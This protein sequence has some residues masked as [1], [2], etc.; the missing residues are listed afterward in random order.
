MITQ[1][2]SG[3]VIAPNGK[4]SS[5][6]MEAIRSL[7]NPPLIPLKEEEIYVRRCRLA[8]DVIDSHGGCFRSEDLPKLL[9]MTW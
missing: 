7:P 4:V 8:G 9:Q 1:E 3:P 5:R 6:D 2:L